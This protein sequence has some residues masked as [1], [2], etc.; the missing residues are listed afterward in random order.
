MQVTHHY[1][2]LCRAYSAVPQGLPV[3]LTLEELAE[4]LHCTVRNVKIVIRKMSESG[5]ITWVPGRGRGN[6]SELHFHYTLEEMLLKQTAE[7]AEKEQFQQAFE[8]IHQY[9]DT[10]LMKEQLL[11]HV[12]R[13]F[14][15]KAKETEQDADVLRLP[16]NK[17]YRTFD[18]AALLFANDVHLSRQLFDTI[19]RYD[20]AADDF[21]PSL[22]HH[23]ESD[24]TCTVWTFYLR[25][26]V[27]FHHGR[28][29]EA[30]D[31]E[32]SLRRL[33]DPGVFS[34]QRWM[35]EDVRQ[36]RVPSRMT[37]QFVL[38]KPHVLFPHCLTS[39]SAAVLPRELCESDPAAYFACPVGTGPFR[40]EIRPGYG[41]LLHANERYYLGRPFLDVVE[42]IL[43]RDYPELVVMTDACNMVQ[44]SPYAPGSKP[45][46][47]WQAVECISS[48]CALLSFNR[49]K[50]G[51]LQ[52]AGLRRFVRSVIR[53]C[54]MVEEL[55][56]SRALAAASFL[57]D[58]SLKMGRDPYRD[59]QEGDTAGIP[60]S[61]DYAGTELT[62]HCKDSCKTVEDFDWIVKRC[63]KAGLHIKVVLHEHNELLTPDVMCE[64][65]LVL[66]EVVLDESETLSLLE[67]FMQEEG[68]IRRM[69][70]DPLRAEL[71][72]RVA[73]LLAEPDP[74][75]RL[76]L[77]DKLESLLTEDAAVHF[78]YHRK[79]QTTY[80]KSVRGLRLNAFGHIDY[81]HIW[82]EPEDP[83]N[84]CTAS[85]D[86]A[87]PV[88]GIR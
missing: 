85:A 87:S 17:T 33:L 65:D 16:I 71:N 86:A 38:S 80:H 75:K 74:R 36:I 18:P 28:E 77:F 41:Y 25:K 59:T 5:W 40:L 46:Q 45:Q 62:L 44:R 24:E 31:A 30:A 63:L 69:F 64:A 68:S 72:R 10:L 4:R 57:P 34:P 84:G 7:F 32:Y 49:R 39:P 60:Y 1:L 13:Y 6:K 88:S 61:P 11:Q 55:G 35:L 9:A 56:E 8:W 27:L 50:E 37:I 73:G 19:V 23:W 2:E 26:G 83:L 58:K 76:D 14:G 42:H 78:L 52:D 82:F 3:S 53:A 67:L 66:Y 43:L 79:M 70:D 47:D 12:S 21:V 15:Y 20:R 22:A 81:R 48:G 29:L 54:A 51:P